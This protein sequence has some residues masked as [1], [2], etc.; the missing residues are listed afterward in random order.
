MEDSEPELRP[1]RTM[2][3][4]GETSLFLIPRRLRIRSDARP[5]TQMRRPCL[6][7]VFFG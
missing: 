4:E 3:C 5:V 6:T 2:W 7:L 1:V